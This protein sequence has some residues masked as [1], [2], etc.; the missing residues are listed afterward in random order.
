M[1]KKKI[2]AIAVFMTAFGLANA[3]MPDFVPSSQVS[4]QDFTKCLLNA[5]QTYYDSQSAEHCA[6][7]RA[8]FYGETVDWLSGMESGGFINKIN[9]YA[10]DSEQFDN[11]AMALNLITSAQILN[12]THEFFA[13]LSERFKN[14][15]SGTPSDIKLADLDENAEA[16]F[17][18]LSNSDAFA[19]YFRAVAKA[20]RLSLM[21]D[22]AKAKTSAQ[23]SMGNFGSIKVDL[24]TMMETFARPSEGQIMNGA[25]YESRLN[26]LESKFVKLLSDD[27]S[28][29]GKDSLKMSKEDIFGGSLLDEDFDSYF[30]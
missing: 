14:G 2:F 11:S 22:E 8:V 1:T 18:K 13:N 29:K 7:I 24:A 30:K 25:S 26:G 4:E 19:A 21:I 5:Q 20:I 27:G 9:G 28:S 10:L 17:V 16:S 3:A 15:R 6:E 12:N 23:S